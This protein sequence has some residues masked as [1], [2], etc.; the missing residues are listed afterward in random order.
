MWV[1]TLLQA[2]RPVLAL[3]PSRPVHDA[4]YLASGTVQSQVGAV[5][6][7]GL[8]AAVQHINGACSRA[9][10]DHQSL[11]GRRQGK[12]AG[13]AT[14]ARLHSAALGN[15]WRSRQSGGR[16][17]SPHF[18]PARPAAV[19]SSWS[20]SGLHAHWLAVQTWVVAL[21]VPQVTVVSTPQMVAGT[22]PQLAPPAA[23]QKVLSAGRMHL[24]WLSVL[25]VCRAGKSAA[26]G[27]ARGGAC[28]RQLRPGTPTHC[29]RPFHQ[30]LRSS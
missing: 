30:L 13:S 11:G 19:H 10:L 23:S 14:A 16:C 17:H 7:A 9:P 29:M 22:S 2:G 3:Q 6:R 27:Q 18:V 5:H 15:C 26:R 24:H 4:P 28:R 21:Q 20:D 25:Q 1:R 12:D 8:A